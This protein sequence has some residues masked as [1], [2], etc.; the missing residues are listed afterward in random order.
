MG[1]MLDE[2]SDL[3]AGAEKSG[4]YNSDKHHANVFQCHLHS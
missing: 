3:I 2:W 1:K 4:L